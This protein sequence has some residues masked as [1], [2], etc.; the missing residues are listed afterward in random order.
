[1]NLLLPIL[2]LSIV[3]SLAHLV[4]SSKK[5]RKLLLLLLGL[6]PLIV[7]YGINPRWRLYTNHGFWHTAIVYRIASGEVPP[8]HPFLAGEPIRYAWG[9]HLLASLPLKACRLAPSYSFA[10]INIVSLALAMILVFKI[11]RILFDNERANV[12]SVIVTLFGFTFI[13]PLLLHPKNPLP[14]SLGPFRLEFR[15]V[16]VFEKFCNANSLPV[17]LVFF[18]LYLLATIKF[19]RE[20]RIKREATVLVISV[21]GCAF[22]YP[23]FLPGI[24]ASA[25]VVCVAR[26][27]LPRTTDRPWR[28]S[29][30]AAA[31]VF[32]SLF[33][34]APYLSPALSGPS[35][36]ARLFG[37]TAV[38]NNLATF[39]LAS[40]PLLVLIGI[41]L[42]SLKKRLALGPSIT[43][44]SVAA[45]NLGCFL[46]V[47][48]PEN[49]E[50]KFLV[51]AT[52]PVG[53]IGGVA[54]PAFREKLGK[55]ATFILLL[56][57]LT[58]S[59]LWVKMRA[60][61]Y[62]WIEDRYGEKEGQIYSR[63]GE[64]DEIRRWIGENTDRDGIIIDSTSTMPVLTGR[65]LFYPSRLGSSGPG[66]A[67]SGI[68]FATGH[69][70]ELLR[71]REAIVQRI[72]NPEKELTGDDRSYLRSLNGPVYLI[73]RS[74]EARGGDGF[75]PV[76]SS[77]RGNLTVHLLR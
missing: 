29:L 26:L 75:Q 59:Y 74:G 20:E 68:L 44:I 56:L 23:P 51:L 65:R 40:A 34:A 11:S 22:F 72:Y 19:F 16:P 45:A 71:K 9:L 36:A 17:G 6:C 73:V 50:Y 7:L 42:S 28:R 21:L 13:H 30:L 54:L 27:F 32:G 48:L 43:L 37:R 69:S 53:V 31:I 57:F 52:V 55:W 24:A 25:L 76:F 66:F 67:V 58:P 5:P 8:T 49:N 18:L 63:D 60:G 47:H 62:R 1:M 3:L 77:S 15:G 38:I 70:P 39:L 2:F 14:A 46:S 4:F 61:R 33:L 12:F 10:L 64:E 35:G 41:S